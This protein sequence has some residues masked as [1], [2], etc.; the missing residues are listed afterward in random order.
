MVHY[1]VNAILWV[2]VQTVPTFSH[3]KKQVVSVLVNPGSSVEFVINVLLATSDMD[4]TDAPNV[5]V[6]SQVQR[7]H[8]VITSLA[9]VRVSRRYKEGNVI[10]VLHFIMDFLTV[11]PV[12]VIAIHPRVIPRQEC[13]VSVT[14]T[15]QIVTVGHVQSVTMVMPRKGLILTA[16][17][18]NAQGVAVVTNSVR[19]AWW[20]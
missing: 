13:V 16:N 11:N 18:V 10:H 19:A 7:V 8:S 15:L 17:G 6:T 3:V 5:T 12:I 20:T 2:H 1:P 9:S 14:T 4:G